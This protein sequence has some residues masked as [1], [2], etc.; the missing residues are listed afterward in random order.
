MPNINTQ[1]DPGSRR[2]QLRPEAAVWPEVGFVGIAAM[3]LALNR[4][5]AQT[6]YNYIAEGLLPPMVDIG[7]NR[8]GWPVEVAR[9]AL[10][11]LP[12]KVAARKAAQRQRVWA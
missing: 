7:P 10:V 6:I 12:A 2:R 4:C 8:V 5:A 9:Q 3:R 1:S 11:D